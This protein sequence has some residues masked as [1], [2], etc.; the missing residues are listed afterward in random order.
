MAKLLKL[1]RGTTTQHGSFTGAEGE[2]TVDTDKETLVVHDGS[3]A[4]GHPV[5]AEDM[6]NVSSASIAGRL[7]NDSIATSKIAAGALPSDVTVAS[8]NI[9]DGTIVN[10]DVNAG[11]AIAG[12]KVSPNFGS[13]SV[14]TTGNIVLSDSSAGGNNRVAFGASGDLQIWH[15]GSNSYLADEGTGALRILGSAVQLKNVANNEIGLEFTENGAVDLY[16]DNSKKLQTQSGGVRVF[17]D[18]ENHNDD[19][20]AKDNCKFISGN[21]DD[22]QLYHDGTNSYLNNTGGI[23]HIKNND[24]RIQSQ[25][26]ETMI[27]GIGDGSVELYHNNSKKIETNGSGADVT[28]NLNVSNGVDV[29]GNLTVSGTV[30]SGATTITGNHSVTGNIST[31]SGNLTVDGIGSVEDTFKITDGAGTQYLLMGN[32]DSAGA[33]SPKVFAVGNANLTIGVGDSWSNNTGGTLTNQF[34]IAKNGTITSYGNH[35][36]NNGIDVTGNITVS[37]TVDGRD[38][39]SDGTKLDGIESGAT[40]DQTA[41]EVISLIH[42]GSITPNDVTA[43]YI[44][45][46][47]KIGRDS[48]DYIQ[49]GNNSQMDVYVNG[50]NEFRFEADGD[51]HADGDVYAFSTTVSSDENLKKDITI[52]SDAVT[53]VEALKGVTFKWKKNDADSAGVIAQDVEK[54]LPEVV[55]TV[56]DMEGNEFKAVNYAG[57]TSILIEAVKDLSARIKV[58]EAK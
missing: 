34:G 40:A 58:L 37:G 2:V 25:G 54:V 21:S 1:R 51:F 5:A 31:T 35:D 47:N 46:T 20:V 13:Q 10:S 11:A 3:T 55:K 38:V 44:Y 33:N 36:F 48:N 39:A 41:S 12:T 18:L 50:S 8:A 42:N 23:L 43:G 49:W 6:A 14:V 15:D 53:K 7:A 4:G 57:L 56:N 16:Y 30:N 22:L 52:V 27:R 24:V 19:F 28:G 9:V 29:T 26:G 32:Q 45:G 17:G